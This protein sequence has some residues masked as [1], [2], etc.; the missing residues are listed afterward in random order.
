MYKIPKNG[1]LINIVLYHLSLTIIS[2]NDKINIKLK[3][4]DEDLL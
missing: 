2:P 3:M 4:K 1:H